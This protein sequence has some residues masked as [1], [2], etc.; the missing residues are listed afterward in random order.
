[1]ALMRSILLPYS[2]RVGSFT[3]FCN[4]NSL[5]ISSILLCLLGVLVCVC[6]CVVF[7]ISQC[8]SGRSKS[9]AITTLGVFL[10]SV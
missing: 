10:R 3:I 5:I 9:P 4:P 6:V 1:M 2:M 8:M 7:W